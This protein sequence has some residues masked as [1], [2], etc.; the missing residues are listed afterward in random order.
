MKDG[1]IVPVAVSGAKPSED[2]EVAPVEK[3]IISA[4]DTRKV[5]LST[6]LS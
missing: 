5:T 1:D 2:H 3:F 6:S 4:G